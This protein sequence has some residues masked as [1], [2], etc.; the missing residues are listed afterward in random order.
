MVDVMIGKATPPGAQAWRWD[1]QEAARCRGAEELFFHPHGER[2]PARSDRDEAARGLCM[3]CPVRRECA[4]FA[5]DNSEPFGV[6]GGY[7]EEQR[8][9][10][11]NGE[12][13]PRYR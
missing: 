4:Q 13:P 6:W 1:W 12:R 2:D 10:L 8:E 9:A 11:L 3:S 7:T 5:L